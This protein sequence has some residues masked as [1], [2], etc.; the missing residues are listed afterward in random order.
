MMK[1]LLSVSTSG[2]RASAAYFENGVMRGLKLSDGVSHSSA[3]GV[4]VNELLNEANC[5]PADL[6]CLAVDIGPGSFTGVRIGVS[7]VNGMAL[8]LN[9]PV[10]PV[11]SLRALRHNAKDEKLVA[12][13]IDARNSSVYAA[14]Y[15]GNSEL[16]APEAY[17]VADF[18]AQIP[19][20]AVCVGDG[21]VRYAETDMHERTS[22]D[23]TVL[24]GS[25]NIVTAEG[26]GRAAC[27]MGDA[28]AVGY[29]VPLYL[30]PSQAERMRDIRKQK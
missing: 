5:A 15:D 30:R 8:A 17:D 21:A 28:D 3:I 26:V 14:L 27:A 20:G 13:M 16:I 11:T 19:T 12:C 29:A 24:P 23:I 4:L 22:E 1:R 6:D 7:F 10:V 2:A 18:A 25:V 9:I